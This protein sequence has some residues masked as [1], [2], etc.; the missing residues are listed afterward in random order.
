MPISS[1]R[2]IAVGAS[3]VCSVER[4]R[5]PVSAAS[6]AIVAVS[7]SRISPTMITSGSA[8]IIERRPVANVRPGLR[9]D[10]D[11]GDALD[12]VLDRVLDGDDVLVGRVDLLERGVQRGGLARARRAG[13]QHGAVGLGEAR[14]RSAP[15]RP[16]A[17]RAFQLHH[18]GLLV[19]DAQH[20]RL[21]VDARQRDDAD[22]D[23]AT[24]DG[25][26]DAA[27]LG[28]A[29]LGDVEVGHDLDARDD[30]ADHAPGHGGRAGEHAVDAEAHA[31][32]VALGLEVDVR[33]ALLD[34]LGDDRVHELDDRRVVGGLAQ[35]DDLGG[36]LA[37][38]SSSTASWTTSSRRLRRLISPWTSSCD[39]TAVRT[40]IPVMIAM[41]ST[42]STLLGSTIATSS[43]R[44]VDEGDGDGARSAW[45]PT[46]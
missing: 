6:T 31:H 46:R 23:L 17:C 38:S 29:P 30:A 36:A 15:P 16:R 33:C 5:W 39:A 26:P 34:R 27:V 11:L 20:D 28:Q 14:P 19:E 35:V 21:A 32:L 25:Q 37:S 4:T 12:L 42:A 2:V 10:L 45:P 22:V 1:R 7:E 8:R 13:D 41:S 44:V 9:V 24:L 18:H 3:F 43:V 40:S